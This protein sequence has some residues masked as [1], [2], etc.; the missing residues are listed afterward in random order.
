MLKMLPYHSIRNDGIHD[1]AL[2]PPG[3]LCSSLCATIFGSIL[4]DTTLQ[5]L[6]IITISYQDD[7][8]NYGI[9]TSL[10]VYNMSVR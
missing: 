3:K 7:L 9:C 4:H 6:K 1:I 10:H 2:I 8:H 5:F